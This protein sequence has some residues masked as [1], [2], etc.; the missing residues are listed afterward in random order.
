MAIKTPGKIII[1]VLAVGGIYF[2]LKKSGALDKIFKKSATIE[3]SVDLPTAPSNAITSGLTFAGIPSDN[4]TTKSLPKLT[5]DIMAWNS[6]LGL[7][8]ANGGGETTEG[9]LME[10]NGVHLTIKRQ[11][12]I[13]QA[14]TEL[15]KFAKDYK[16]NAASATGTNMFIMMG[17]GSPATLAALNEKLADLGAEYQAVVIGAVGRSNGE[18]A[19]MAPGAWKENPQ[20]A[21]GGVI[22]TVIRDGDWNIVAKWAKDNNLKLN[23]DERTYDPTALNFI[24]AADFTKS[25]EMYINGYTEDRPVVKDGVKTGQ[26]KK[27]TVEAVSTWT[28]ADVTIATKK[29]GLV[30]I[31]STHEYSSQMAG[32]IITIKKFAEDNRST[33]VNFLSAALQ[34]GDQVKSYSQALDKAGEV[35]AK[36]YNE[37]DGAY[38]V[39]YA[40]G[41]IQPD[42]TSTPVELGGSAQFNLGD[43]LN[44]F[45]LAP[46][47]SNIYTIVY[48]T[49]SSIAKQYYSDMFKSFPEANSIQDLSYLQ[50]LQKK[51]QSSGQTITAASTQTYSVGAGTQTIS[52]KSY[53]IEFA[54]GSAELT[55][56][57]RATVDD[58]AN[59]LLVAN[60]LKATIDGYTDNTGSP[61]RNKDL[62][63][64]RAQAVKAEIQRVSSASFPDSRFTVNGY[65]SDYTALINAR[66]HVG[67]NG[68]ADGRQDNRRVQVSM[69]K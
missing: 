18:D 63:L 57:G 22:A 9:S 58:I 44:Y 36:I 33:I 27:I 29:G 1:A 62:S 53:A 37:Q 64:Q 35:S 56:A 25:A 68:T 3:A 28:P 10:K 16:D 23:P 49:F 34:G 8:F 19:L 7:L 5:L 6:Q 4:I 59:S 38:W 47:S 42:K 31:V 67:D 54:I 2:G 51:A 48:N 50:D 21:V 11:D 26:T 15:I 41:T 13:N 39:K 43:N 17:D 52:S 66:Q 55:A 30:R 12:D 65:G 14:S 60:G 61:E 45:G 40:K 69:T 32:V 20:N 24:N 46:G